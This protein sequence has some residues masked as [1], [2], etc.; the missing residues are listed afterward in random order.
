LKKGGRKCETGK[1]LKMK[2]QKL[3]KEK[4]KIE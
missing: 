4:G 3:R 1:S 2:R